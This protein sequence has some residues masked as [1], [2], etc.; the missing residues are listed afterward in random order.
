MGGLILIKPFKVLIK[1]IQTKFLITFKIYIGI[2]TCTTFLLYV[3]YIAKL[4]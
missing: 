2:N 4:Y 1:Y 3:L